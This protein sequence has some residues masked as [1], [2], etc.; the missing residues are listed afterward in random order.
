LHSPMPVELQVVS[1]LAGT[2]GLADDV[3]V[4]AVRRFEQELHEWMETRFSGLLAEIRDTGRIPEGDALDGAL[5]EFH[6]YFVAGLADESET[7]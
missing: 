2:S 5:K 6:D 3:P 4:E 7:A 1:V